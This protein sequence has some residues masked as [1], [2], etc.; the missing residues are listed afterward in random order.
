MDERIKKAFDFASDTTKQLITLAT[1]VIALTITFSKDFL[2]TV[3]ADAK[4]FA[5]WAWF[6]YLFSILCGVWTLL[7]LTGTLESTAAPSIRG[8]NV[9]LPSILQILAFLAAT[10]LTV[11][12]GIRAIPG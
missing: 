3:P 7:A 11:L 4:G 6:A 2:G 5:T 1:G 9:R 8:W 10:L 12:F